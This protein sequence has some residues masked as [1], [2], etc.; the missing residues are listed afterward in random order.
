MGQRLIAVSK[1]CIRFDWCGPYCCVE[2]IVRN[3][4]N[5]WVTVWFKPQAT[6]A[7]ARDH[8]PLIG[9]IILLVLH[10]LV[11]LASFAVGGSVEAEVEPMSGK[12]RIGLYIDIWLMP[13]VFLFVLYLVGKRLQG[14]AD[15]KN[16]LWV[17][18]WSQLPI[19][20]MQLISMPLEIAGMQISEP[21]FSNKISTE[22]GV[23]VID[24]PVMQLNM[25][26]VVYFLFST[27]F[28]LWSF[29]ILLSGLAAVEGVTLKRAMWILTLAMI[30]LMLIRLPVTIALA[31]RDLM[32]ILGLKG[33]LEVN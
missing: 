29:Q 30:A 14:V 4:I 22:N 25:D 1:L 24:P 2:F 11:T 20:L 28:L 7:W 13:V 12:H 32:D 3:F 19:I 33:I 9:V 31:D 6:A 5:P 16:V 27:V 21:L 23:L 8:R 15:F 17:V 26:A 10:V 18:V